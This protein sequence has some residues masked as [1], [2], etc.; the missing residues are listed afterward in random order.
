MTVILVITMVI[1]VLLV[2]WY[3]V[4]R[5]KRITQRARVRGAIPL[6]EGA[7]ADRPPTDL[8]HHPGHTWVRVHDDNLVSVG[9]TDFAMHFAG[10]L[11]AAKLPKEGARLQQGDPAWTLISTRGRQLPQQMPIEGKVLAVNDELIRHPELGQRAPYD[12]GWILRVRPRDLKNNIRNLFSGTAAA[13]WNDA[14]RASI[15]RRLSPALGA[16]A[17]DGGEWFEGF[18][19][20]LDDGDWEALRRELFPTAEVIVGT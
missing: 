6:A 12:K 13:I 3:L 1:T 19:D 9:A 5:R 20:R 10:Q 17:H 4:T 16:L 7:C 18:G 14:A 8:L 2:E 11:A 15:T